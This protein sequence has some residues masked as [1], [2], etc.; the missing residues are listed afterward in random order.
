MPTIINPYKSGST[1][2]EDIFG[3]GGLADT[4]FG[5]KATTAA[6]TR[7][8]FNEARRINENVPLYAAA[9]A[10]NTDPREIVR[11][12][13]LADQRGAD[14]GN[15]IRTITA[16]T[17]PNDLSGNRVTAALIGA[18]GPMSATPQ[19]TTNELANRQTI[20]QM[21]IDKTLA[22]QEA[23]DARSLVAVRDQY[24]NLTWTRKS[25]APGQG[26]PITADQ[27]RG[28]ALSRYLF[29]QMGGAD[30]AAVF[31]DPG[32]PQTLP[33][34]TLTP[35][36]TLPGLGSIPAAMPPPMTAPRAPLNPQQL[37]ALN[38]LPTDHVQNWVLLDDTGTKVIRRGRTAGNNIDVD[39]NQPMPVGSQV[40]SPLT[41]Q[42][43]AGLTTPAAPG[44]TE[45]KDYR[46]AINNADSV[47]N[48]GTKINDIVDRNPTAIGAVGNLRLL[49]Q[50]GVDLLNSLNTQFGGGRAGGYDT[51]VAQT[52]NEIRQRLGAGAAQLIPEL[53]DSELNSV[54][55]M[56]GMMIYKAAA[57]LGQSG[58]D[59][60]DKDI[61]IVRGLVGDPSS[62]FQGPNTYK[63]KINT[64]MRIVAEQRDS[65]FTMIQPGAVIG[66]RTQGPGLTP[67][68]AA[69]TTPPA[70]TAA[71]V[72]GGTTQTG[73]TW[74][75]EP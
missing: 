37:K 38:A 29:P 69:T 66:A 33:D 53:F 12:G 58:R 8:K 2:G 15:V 42:G 36:T 44:K 59:A 30:G 14:M 75:L 48:L 43:V 9:A 24:G 1:M 41:A 32:A 68:P 46:S 39:T 22:A 25:D 21:Q 54:R 71:P 67:A 51:A 13:I 55:T 65:D 73:R 63:D 7:E 70:A 57:A 64:I 4:F 60:S 28:D 26:A 35:L 20:A 50:E 31:P 72:I 6:Y 49:G 34:A 19:G 3:L 27:A 74:K 5:P 45:L 52:R 10:A 23:Q 40:I 16:N 47:L 17:N 11:R 62:W 56:N 61:A 18:G